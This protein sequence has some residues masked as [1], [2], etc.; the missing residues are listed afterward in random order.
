MLEAEEVANEFLPRLLDD[1]GCGGLA[2]ERIFKGI[3]E[4]QDAG[5]KIELARLEEK[6]SAADKQVLYEILF[7]RWE[8]PTHEQVEEFLSTIKRRRLQRERENLQSA[9]KAAE[10]ERDK[11]KLAQL[12]QAKVK[13][14]KDLAQSRLSGE[15]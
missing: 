13:L 1:V 6:L 15:G 10:R 14:E 8:R 11:P 9:I 2:T 12:L 7:W 4:L 5:E 3:A